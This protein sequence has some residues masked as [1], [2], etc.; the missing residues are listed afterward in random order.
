M[1]DSSMQRERYARQL[2]LPEIGEQGQQKLSAAKVLVV[3]L[4]G[5]GSPASLYLV[6]AGVGTVGL[7]D[8]DVLD[9]SNLQ[10]QIVHSTSDV[11][12]PKVLSARD[13]LSAL[14]PHVKLRVHQLAL[15]AGNACDIIREYDFVVDATDNFDAKFLVADSCHALSVPY[16]HA[17]ILRSSGQTMTVMP[18]RTACYRCVFETPPP[19]DGKPAGPLGAVPGVIGAIQATEAIKYVTGAGSLLTDRLLIYDGL[20]MT[21]RIVKARRAPDCP[22]CGTR[23]RGRAR[24]VKGGAKSKRGKQ[25][26]V[27]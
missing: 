10:R 7:L 21:V 19:D 1:A 24:D 27:L 6:A 12:R 14:N 26:E 11:G 23:R 2:S 18:G 3:G 22:L 8:K 25:D 16:S 15:S 9:L 5:L 17:G 20:A 13:R 4:G